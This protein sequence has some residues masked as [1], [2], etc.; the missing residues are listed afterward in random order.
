MTPGYRLRNRKKFR[1]Q[2]VMPNWKPPQRYTGFGSNGRTGHPPV[3]LNRGTPQVCRASL[4]AARNQARIKRREVIK[5]KRPNPGQTRTFKA[6]LHR[7]MLSEAWASLLRISVQ[8]EKLFNNWL[9]TYYRY[10]ISIW[11]NKLH[12]LRRSEAM[13][14]KADKQTYNSDC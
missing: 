13:R 4:T 10:F 6:P 5:K 12:Y 7:V 3:I 2:T 14:R 8:V 1:L 11:P 9:L